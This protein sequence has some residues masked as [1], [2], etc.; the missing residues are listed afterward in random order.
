M[1]NIIGSDLVLKD[2]HKYFDEET[3]L[4]VSMKKYYTDSEGYPNE[5]A[6]F[7]YVSGLQESDEAYLL[8][9]DLDLMATNAKEGRGFADR[10]MRSVFVHISEFFPVFRI[11]GTKFNIIVYN[12]EECLTN[13]RTFLDSEGKSEYFT[14]HGELVTDTFLTAGNV[15]EQIAKGIKSMYKDRQNTDVIVG[16]MMNTPTEEQETAVHK[17]DGDLWYATIDF[18]ESVPNIRT[19]KAYVF[20]IEYRKPMELLN[21]IVVLDDLVAQPRLFAGT[22]VVVPID[23]MKIS[24]TARFDTEGKLNISY[25][26]DTISKGQIIGTISTHDG[27]WI[28]LSFGKRIGGKK[29][30]FPVKL[31]RQ[32]LY[33]FVLLNGN[34]GE[35][36]YQDNGLIYGKEK[37]YEVHKNKLGIDLTPTLLTSPKANKA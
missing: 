29:E 35:I 3:Q 14:I 23:G 19:L 34:T 24:I 32:G 5:K 30:I 16:E 37:I 25:I 17:S 2:Y 12:K 10:L 26:K 4:S 27:K 11:R 9:I 8:C 20:P 6:F 31:N 13:I 28:P 18:D 22:N 15:N 21:C 33:E 36:T 7:D 1:D